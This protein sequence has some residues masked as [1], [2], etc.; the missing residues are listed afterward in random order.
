MKTI[1]LTLIMAGILITAVLGFAEQKQID[2]KALK[3]NVSKSIEQF[4]S[5][6]S[7]VY[8]KGIHDN[9]TFARDGDINS[10]PEIKVLS[11]EG[12]VK[13][14]SFKSSNI[15]VDA[16][17]RDILIKRVNKTDNLTTLDNISRA[18]MNLEDNEV[19]RA[20]RAAVREK[21]GYTDINLRD[22]LTRLERRLDNYTA[23]MNSLQSLYY[24]KDSDNGSLV[25]AAGKIDLAGRLA[26]DVY[27]V[28]IADGKK[29]A[30]CEDNI[31][32]GFADYGE[33][34]SVNAGFYEIRVLGGDELKCRY[35]HNFVGA[36]GTYIETDFCKGKVKIDELYNC[37]ETGKGYVDYDSCAAGCTSIC[38]KATNYKDPK[39]KWHG[40]DVTGLAKYTQDEKEIMVGKELGLCRDTG[41][42]GVDKRCMA[43]I[44]DWK[45][46]KKCIAEG[47][48]FTNHYYCCYSDEMMMHLSQAV[49]VQVGLPADTCE[50]IPLKDFLRADLNDP[51]IKKYLKSK[52]LITDEM[53]VDFKGKFESAETAAGDEGVIAEKSVEFSEELTGAV[54]KAKDNFNFTVPRL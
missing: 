50:G 4:K 18:V 41:R 21:L 49:K 20:K 1:V 5:P 19:I 10:I 7:E 54:E 14:M 45:G 40:I 15:T 11:G 12:D 37:K 16:A 17:A 35:Q 32:G 44:Y 29:K 3:E 31:I 36:D 24:D 23:Y 22:N 51:E 30:D 52:G 9:F 38:A 42:T 48:V 53:L 47:K 33:D 27:N 39:L 43:Y 28:C 6:D 8:H 2:L 13:S 46:D 26:E 25:E 34:Y